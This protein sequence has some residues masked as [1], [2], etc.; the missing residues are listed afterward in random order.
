VPE[1]LALRGISWSKNKRL[2]LVNNQS[3]EPGESGKVRLG[4]T[5][6]TIRCLEVRENSVRIQVLDS[7]E[8]IELSL[9]GAPR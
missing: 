3:F 9:N 2:A 8:E 1:K 4:T 5:N 7:G 6:V